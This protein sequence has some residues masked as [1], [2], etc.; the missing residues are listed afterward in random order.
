MTC[1]SKRSSSATDTANHNTHLLRAR[2]S[3]ILLLAPKGLG[4]YGTPESAPQRNRIAVSTPRR[5]RDHYLVHASAAVLFS[6]A[7]AFGGPMITMES[8]TNSQQDYYNR[9]FLEQKLSSG[10]SAQDCAWAATGVQRWFSV[11]S[12]VARGLDFTQAKLLDTAWD[13][14]VG[15][16]GRLVHAWILW[17]F[18]IPGSVTRLLEVSSLPY[19]SAIQFAFSPTSLST[20]KHSLAAT[21]RQR[22]GCNVSIA[23]GLSFLIGH[24]VSFA[25]LWSV[26]TAYMN[27][28]TEMFKTPDGTYVNPVSEALTLCYSLDVGRLSLPQ[29]EL[30]PGY[31]PIPSIV[32]GPSLMNISTAI[33]PESSEALGGINDHFYDVFAC[34]S[35]WKE[36]P[37]VVNTARCCA[38]AYQSQMS[39][40]KE[41]SIMASKLSQATTPFAQVPKIFST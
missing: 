22:K 8:E 25:T 24:T 40:L 11:D 13:L 41:S 12:I 16:G 9:S 31:V 34:K 5:R 14:L 32:N 33:R 17:R 18:I 27:P 1:I 3:S 38:A 29:Q 7:C 28:S 35:G 39:P 2:S 26:A 10:S 20:L 15:Q 36:P 19:A 23:I 30:S 6:L 4:N 21:F 37:T